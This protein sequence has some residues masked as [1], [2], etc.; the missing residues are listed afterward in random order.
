MPCKLIRAQ[1]WG[2]VAFDE[3]LS[4]FFFWKRDPNWSGFGSNFIKDFFIYLMVE[5]WIE[6]SVESFP[7][8]FSS[9]TWITFIFDGFSC[10]KF[11]LVNP[12][13]QLS[14][15]MTLVRNFSDLRLK[16][17]PFGVLYDILKFLSAFQASWCSIFID[18]LFTLDIPPLFGVSCN[19]R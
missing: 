10:R 6:Y 14:W 5:S 7:E 13:H 17:W 15:A 16:K 11:A 9:D 18:G 8:A 3:S 19:S 1:S 2:V 4:E 12:I